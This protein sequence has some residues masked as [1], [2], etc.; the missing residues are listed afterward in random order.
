MIYILVGILKAFSNPDFLSGQK[1]HVVMNRLRLAISKQNAALGHARPT[2]FKPSPPSI[3]SPTAPH[4]FD[5]VRLAGEAIERYAKSDD[6][7]RRQLEYPGKLVCADLHEWRGIEFAGALL[8][9]THIDLV[10]A[11]VQK[12]LKDVA[13]V[14][15]SINLL[16]KHVRL[17]SMFVSKLLFKPTLGQ[18]LLNGDIGI[19]TTYYQLGVIDS[20]QREKWWMQAIHN[21]NHFSCR[22][23]LIIPRW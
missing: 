13:G 6:T 16:V 8:V 15:T 17:A 4:A 23:G 21:A 20:R 1:V 11:Q 14:F 9:Q 2:P 18:W 12:V 22:L 19:S 7:T 5:P 10:H 3:S